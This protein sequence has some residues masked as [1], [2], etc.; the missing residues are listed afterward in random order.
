MHEYPL[1]TPPIA[2]GRRPE[3]GVSSPGLGNG[4]YMSTIEP[5]TFEV[6]YHLGEYKSMV[7]E[8]ILFRHNRRL[9]KKSPGA[10]AAS[11]LPLSIGAAFTVFVPFVYFYKIRKV[12]RCAFVIDEDG[13]QRTSKL[14]TGRVPWSDVVTVHR[15]SRAYLVEKSQ[16]AF[17]LPY[18]CL[19]ENQAAALENLFQ[20]KGVAA[21]DPLKR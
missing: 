12:G 11:R 4:F 8:Y 21:A 10:Q 9:L 20:A 19:D 16:D 6:S 18:R 17:P 1:Q 5:V 13:V 3:S 2:V 14:G 7:S 15:L